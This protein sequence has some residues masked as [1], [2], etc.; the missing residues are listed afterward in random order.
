[1]LKRKLLKVKEGQSWKKTPPNWL[2]LKTSASSLL[3]AFS[4]STLQIPATNYKQTKCILC[5]SHWKALT[6][7]SWIPYSP[8]I[9]KEFQQ[10]WNSGGGVM[11]IDTWSESWIKAGWKMSALTSIP[12]FGTAWEKLFQQSDCGT[13][14]EGQRLPPQGRWEVLGWWP[15]GNWQEQLSEAAPA[16]LIIIKSS[17]N[18]VGWKGPF[19]WSVQNYCNK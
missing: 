4:C 16:L 19:R 17:W 2:S 10:V 11:W 5:R 18:G 3:F 8:S 1:M 7:P 13:P 15:L 12:M 14:T 6:N 9:W